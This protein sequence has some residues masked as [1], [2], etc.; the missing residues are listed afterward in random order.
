[1]RSIS[2]LIRPALMPALVALL[3]VGCTAKA[4]QA[5]HTRRADRYFAAGQYDKAEIEYIKVLR[6]APNNLPATRRL[7][8]IYAAEGRPLPAIQLL[9]KAQG[10]DTNDLEVR[11]TLGRTYL[12]LGGAREAR[13]EANFVLARSPTNPAALLLL[14]FSAVSP[15]D[16]VQSRQRLQTL[17]QQRGET[18]SAQAAL[19]TLSLRLG[20][21]KAAQAAYQRAIALDAKCG[22]AYL[23]LGDVYSM[24][25]DAKQA[26][27]AYKTGADLAPVRSLEHLS[28]ARYKIQLGALDEAK[29][30]LEEISNQAPD[31]LPALRLLAQIDLAQKKF[32]DCAA[33]LQRILARE[34]VDYDG[35]MLNGRLQMAQGQPAQA[36]VS[37][38][39]LTEAYARMPRP[40]APPYYE[41]AASQL[42]NN[43]LAKAADNLNRAVASAYGFAVS[44]FPTNELAKATNILNRILVLDP[45]YGRATLLLAQLSTRR[46]LAGTAV[47]SL[48]QFLR[49]LEQASEGGPPL[50][51]SEKKQLEALLAPKVAQAYLFLINAYTTQKNPDQALAVCGRWGRR[52]P[53]DPR[54][55]FYAGL[56]RGGQNLAGEAKKEFEAA[57]QLAPEFDKAMNIAPE[58]A[59]M[60][61]ALLTEQLV[62]ADLVEKNFPAALRRVE[63]AIQQDPTMAGLKLLLA[64]VYAAQG[65][66]NRAEAT[67]KKIIEAD[68]KI[69]A[70]YSML[71]NL[72]V[73][74]GNRAQ[75]LQE[76]AS[77]LSQ[78]PSNAPALMMK[79]MILETQKDYT[80]ALDTYEKLLAVNSTYGPALNNAAYLYAEQR[81][82]LDKAC[83]LAQKARD[84]QPDDPATAD[85][86]GW[87]LLQR[88]EYTRALSL[89]QESADKLPGEP[90][91]LYHLGMA[92]YL[93][94]EEGPARAAFQAALA[95][96]K[97]FPSKAKAGQRL[98]L[99]ALDAGATDPK[100]ID[101]LKKQLAETPDD[102]VVLVRLGRLYEQT[103]AFDQARDAYATA[104]RRNPN[105]ATITIRLAQLYAGPLHDPKKAMELAKTARN[106]APD[107]A[108]VTYLLGRLA[109]QAGDPQWG[110]SLLQ[111]SSRKLANQPELWYD[112]GLAS[113]N[114]GRVAE[115]EAAVGRALQV[116]AAFAHADA[117]KRFLAMIGL[118]KNPAQ[119]G[120]SAAQVQQ[121][122]KDD[123]NCTPA[124]FASGLLQEQ[125][126]DLA[127][128]R[129][130]YKKILDQNPLFTPA[131]RQLVLLSVR[132]PADDK[133]TYE[134]ALKAREAFPQDPEVAKALGMLAFRRGDYPRA[135]QLL[136]ESSAQRVSDAELFYYLGLAQNQLKQKAASANSLRKA[137]AL[138][139]KT[140]LADEA[141]RILGTL[142]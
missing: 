112:L 81:K 11:L 89:L 102:P 27:E 108:N 30:L 18:A 12:P 137:L 90:E 23:G 82:D 49:M 63:A 5:W 77:V 25:K 33:A 95:T 76:L 38:Q 39:R 80:A 138:N 119:I 61:R 10:M 130:T 62:K 67:L 26:E 69:P 31:Y 44:R 135:A 73:A 105:S 19:G 117:A 57:L 3:A 72:Y 124:V 48:T 85:T 86:L 75:A 54:P 68:P 101:D 79:G 103:G 7:G 1:M 24:Q 52:F 84:V 45:V 2:R 32:N 113:Y 107:D 96:Q 58:N 59:R 83:E 14:A 4:K 17:I 53:D 123:P 87:I 43:D 55:R 131:V 46:G 141:Q 98:A 40:F 13:N 16:I 78:T 50:G 56:I 41:L 42:A 99:L 132:N 104:L 15:D 120:A 109:C 139:L 34:P 66:T 140:P 118:G 125:R 94:L 100:A 142:K 133:E 22:A 129:Q 92:H 136:T 21:I 65:D 91:V 6:A 128:A 97:D 115:A 121:A 51:P 93:R 60:D 37:F 8:L 35:L 110:L 20:D 134:L 74:E 127:A 64:Q 122:L 116:N 126:G 114:V 70:A 111:E 29:K 71:A 88:G 106:L 47:A 9:S 28:Y 36:A